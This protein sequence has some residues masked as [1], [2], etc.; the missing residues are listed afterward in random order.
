MVGSSAMKTDVYL[1]TTDDAGD[2]TIVTC[3]CVDLG[4]STRPE[5]RRFIHDFQSRFGSPPG[6]FG[7]EGWDAG[8][9]LLA[10]FRAGARDRRTVAAA[11]S[12][13]D[14]YEGLANTYRFDDDGELDPGSAHV[15]VFR[16][17]GVRWNTVGGEDAEEP[18]PVGT[19]GSLS[20]AACR[21]GRPFAYRAGGHVT[22]FDVEL[23]AA[24]AR[25]LGLSLSWRDLPCRTASRAVS[26][27]TLD[28]V[29]TS[30]ADVGQGTPTSGIALSLHL[31]LV[32][33][34]RLARDERP[35]L[36]RLGPGDVVVVVR[37]RESLAWANG[38][39]RATGAELRFT[40]DRRTAYED[41][42]AGSGHGRGR[43]RAGGVACDRT[44]AFA[45]GR[46]EH[47]RGSP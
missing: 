1:S 7:A 16:A 3:A 14:G 30:S 20:V 27:G 38:D 26:S 22:G 23:A 33:S 37:S 47:R 5:A 13:A 43:R 18:L 9:M 24:I 8:G 17:D 29:L 39:L 31:A 28:A 6:V 45:P 41:L 4:S 42:V 21:K 36:Q 2:G 44:A 40:S 12:T 35:L 10:A 46:P 11:L 32:A 19:P 34:R 15:H 25:R